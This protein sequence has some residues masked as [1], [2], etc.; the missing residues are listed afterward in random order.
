MPNIIGIGNSQ[1]P[2]NA[3]L[4]G[5]AYQDSI[6][7]IN[8]EKIKAQ[9]SDIATDIFIYDTSKD[10][11][12][13]A[14]RHK[15][16]TQ[17]WYHERPSQYRGAKKEFPSVAVI[18]GVQ[19]NNDSYLAIYD[20]DEP[21]MPLWMKFVY[22]T[23]HSLSNQTLLY[24]DVASVCAMNGVVAVG[25]NTGWRDG[26]IQI[27][28]IEDTAVWRNSSYIAYWT[29]TIEN[30][31]VVGGYSSGFHNGSG[32]TLSGTP[33]VRALD[34]AVLPAAQFTE[35]QF[36]DGWQTTDPISG[37]PIPAILVGTNSH[38][39]VIAPDDKVYDITGFAPTY[40]VGYSDRSAYIAI[41][42]GG[43][44]FMA[45]G[46]RE[47][48]G[49][50]DV[51]LQNWEYGGEQY[52]SSK[53]VARQLPKHCGNMS[54]IT[55]DDEI[56]FG[57]YSD[58]TY[59]ATLWKMNI[60][61]NLTDKYTQTLSESV[62]LNQKCAITTSFN[63]GWMHGECIAAQ[64]ASTDTSNL[65]DTNLV[66]N[67]DFSNGSTGWSLHGLTVNTSGGNLVMTS[68]NGNQRIS[69]AITVEEGQTYY[70]RETS[71]GSR[72][73]YISTN[74]VS[75]GSLT[76][77]NNSFFTVPPGT[78]TVYV[79]LYVI[80]TG[81]SATFDDIIV[82]KA[83]TDRTLN[84]KRNNN[85]AIGLRTIG[86]LNRNPVA[87]GAELVGYSNFSTSNY[88]S[89]PYNS[90]FDMAT[91]SFTI[92]F[93]AK[94]TGAG[95]ICRR[96]VGDA[97][98]TFRIYLDGSSYGVYFD[99]GNQAQYAQLQ[100]S[101]EKSILVNGRWNFVACQCSANNSNVQI[102]LNGKNMDVNVNANPPSTFNNDSSAEFQVGVSYNNLPFP[103]EI[104]LLRV[105]KHRTS[106]RTL[107]K[108]YDDERRMFQPNAKCTVYGTS[109]TATAIGVDDKKGIVH[110]GTS[111][112]RSDFR[113]LVRINN[114]T[115]AVAR[116]IDA[117]NGLV[118]DS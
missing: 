41:E 13:G 53:G 100:H 108:I 66:T 55:K 61:I 6:G 62:E 57:V 11:D 75:S 97:T 70:F 14:W 27:K 78:T 16:V 15:A 18:I 74:T 86:T 84:N 106:I 2:T 65:T 47:V 98:E 31:N 44:S 8:L 7:E 3:M 69:Q 33:Q 87:T 72:S 91:G 88:L 26:V 59:K 83:D 63:S 37:L 71:S 114:T 118:A 110:V 115:D 99:Y 54:K 20:G 109:N 40:Q 116:V 12:G 77:S 51:S 38:A 68:T 76:N 92:M 1:A 35:G 82:T 28:F 25:G 60:G 56:N 30:R 32:Q 50:G 94:T 29:D 36:H 22:G 102:F 23:Q 113:G 9:T 46:P 43:T 39:C 103:G 112:G 17:S 107:E 81:N 58:M 95:T 96:G 93:W 48:A 4:G 42:T 85:D 64:L 80:G 19:D 89:Q 24:N 79:V 49:S 45:I 5:L 111:S 67:G 90:T 73:R 117:H 101:S 105:T 10:S 21:N 52:D 34:M 104:A